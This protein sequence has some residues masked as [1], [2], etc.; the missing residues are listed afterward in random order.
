M[1]NRGL[2]LL[3]FVIVLGV[4]V[5]LALLFSISLRTSQAQIRDTQRV[6]DINAIQTA[7][8]FYFNAHGAYPA[9]TSEQ[10]NPWGTLD[11]LLSPYLPDGLMPTPPTSKETY[12]YFFSGENPQQYMIAARLDQSSNKNLSND[13]DGAFPSNDTIKEGAGVLSSGAA[14]TSLSCADPVYCVTQ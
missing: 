1:R 3:E 4:L 9:P 2:T 11:E 10:G 14:I 12:V 5:F 13:N 6:T 7:V 8:E